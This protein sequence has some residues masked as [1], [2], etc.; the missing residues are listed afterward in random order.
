MI[1]VKGNKNYWA[2]IITTIY[3]FIGFTQR[4]FIGLNNPSFELVNNYS[5][6]LFIVILTPSLFFFVGVVLFPEQKSP[7][8]YRDFFQRRMNL[9]LVL[10]I[11]LLVQAT[12]INVSTAIVESGLSTGE[13]LRSD[14]FFKRGLLLTN[15]MHA[16][17]IA[18]SCRMIYKNSL[19][20]YE[21]GV[22]VILP[23]FLY[24]MFK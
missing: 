20:Q 13:F 17:L 19:K 7:I 6:F 8:D 22:L 9:F 24:L 16:L 1:K 2:H 5:S 23:Y 18:F 21:I 11:F 14:L 4:Y 15:M 3:L 12:L 10:F